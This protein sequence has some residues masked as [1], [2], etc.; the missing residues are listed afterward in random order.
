MPGKK[1]LERYL[2]DYTFSESSRIRKDEER[3]WIPEVFCHN[4]H[5][6]M[7]YGVRFDGLPAIHVRVEA[8]GEGGAEDYYLSPIVNDPRKEGRDLPEGTKLKIS[9]P[10]CKEEFKQLV[11]CSCRVG[12]YRRAIYLS[13][14]PEELGAVGIC[15]VYGCPQSFVTEDGELLYEVVVE[16]GD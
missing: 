14:N 4:G 10:V 7:V 6:L 9:C 15:E 11:P 2:D 1:K 12:A 16:G 8:E 13:P 5:S 3:I